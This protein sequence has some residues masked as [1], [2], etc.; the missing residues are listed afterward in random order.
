[1][2]RAEIFEKIVTICKDVFD[3]EEL[4]ISENTCPEDVEEWDS[5]THLSL[6]NEVE[7]SFNI[8]LTFDEST[9]IKCVG[10]L[11]NIVENHTK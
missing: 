8:T 4:T 9:N 1:M 6:L 11:I 2:N 3:N 10:D 7:D 5:L